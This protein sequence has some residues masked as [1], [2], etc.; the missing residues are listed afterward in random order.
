MGYMYFYDSEEKL[1]DLRKNVEKEARIRLCCN[2]PVQKAAVKALRGPQDHIKEMVEKLR[3]RRDYTWK[4]L[5]EI[6][7]ISCAKPQGAFYVFP[8]V[9]EIGSR[10]K[11]DFEFV[12]KVLEETQVLLVH[13]SGFGMTY[14]SGHFRGV[15]LPK[16]GVLETALDRLER[17]MTA[18][19]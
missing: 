8:K 7:G 10:W 14:G 18:R 3:K 11:S 9:Q 12:R 15:F 1:T 6:N 2:T 5:N 13:G 19:E 16:V 4:R 17:F